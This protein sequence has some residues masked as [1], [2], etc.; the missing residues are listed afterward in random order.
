MRLGSFLLIPAALVAQIPETQ[1]ALPWER[2]QEPPWQLG[3]VGPEPIPLAPTGQSLDKLPLRVE[4]R[5]DGSLRI[6]NARGL[7]TLRTGL[8]GR[9]IRAWRDAGVMLDLSKGVFRFPQRFGLHGGI[10]S[11]PL[12]PGEDFRSLLSGL[13]WVLDDGERILTILNPARAQVAY[14]PLP[15][16]NNLDLRFFPDHLEAWTGGDTVM[17]RRERVVWTLPWVALLPQFL[18]LASP[19]PSGPL[20][21]ALKPF[22]TQQIGTVK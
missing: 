21:T 2:L 19:R 17:G 12:A 3:A 10:G 8:P 18:T 7:V 6:L 1:K 22:P 20:G 5:S 13:L 16:G 15:A 9:P 4:L 14:V 11:M